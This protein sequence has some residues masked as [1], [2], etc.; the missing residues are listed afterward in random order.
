[1][2]IAKILRCIAVA[3]VLINRNN[4]DNSIIGDIDLVQ[5]QQLLTQLQSRTKYAVYL[6]SSTLISENLTLAKIITIGGNES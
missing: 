5:G 6:L 3:I 4:R 2:N 1:M